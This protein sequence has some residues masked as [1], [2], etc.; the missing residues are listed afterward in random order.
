MENMTDFSPEMRRSL[1]KAMKQYVV[2]GVIFLFF[3][4]TGSILNKYTRSLYETSD[5]F[6]EFNVKY[7]NILAAIT[8]IERTSMAIKGLIPGEFEKRSPEEFLLT[9]LD[10]VKSIFGNAEVMITNIETKPNEAQ[11][12]VTIKSVL[13]DYTLFTNQVGYLQSM[14]FPFFTINSIKIARPLEK[15]P[16]LTTFEISGFLKCPRAGVPI[17]VAPPGLQQ[18][19]RK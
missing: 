12:P 14:K 8:D 19:G 4:I 7:F 13:K 2:A 10:E 5:K 9:G 15:G 6:Q 16:S 11:L 3:I 1:K 17:A 18:R